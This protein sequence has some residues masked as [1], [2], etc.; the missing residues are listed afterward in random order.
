MSDFRVSNFDLASGARFRGCF[1]A[2]DQHRS[3]LVGFLGKRR[4]LFRFEQLGFDN[5]VEPKRSFVG[6]FF[7]DGGL[8]DEVGARFRSAEGA[9]I[10]RYRGSASAQFEWRSYCPIGSAATPP[11]ASEYEGKNSAFFSSF[12]LR[13]WCRL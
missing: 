11:P 2:R 13:S 12:P 3:Q 1:A 8:V 10:R 5:H 7:H 4:N 9:I 6:F